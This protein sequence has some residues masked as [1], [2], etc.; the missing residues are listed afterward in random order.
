MILNVLS[1]YW[2]ILNQIMYRLI[3]KDYTASLASHCHYYVISSYIVY[4]SKNVHI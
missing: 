4:G 2:I 3:L 1:V